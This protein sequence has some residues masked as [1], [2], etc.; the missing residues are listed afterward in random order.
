MFNYATL[1]HITVGCAKGFI[2]SRQKI[3]QFSNKK[4]L[5]QKRT[6]QLH[7][8]FKEIFMCK[9]TSVTSCEMLYT[10]IRL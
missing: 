6:F 2:K 7:T 3:T 10:A 9:Y 1:Q 5:H 4:D 8:K